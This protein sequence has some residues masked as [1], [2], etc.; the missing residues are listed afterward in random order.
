MV[1]C[2]ITIPIYKDPSKVEEASYRQ[3]LKILG[4]HDIC[5]LTFKEL[6]TSIYERIAD[7]YNVKVKFEFFDRMFFTSVSG[8]N[9]LCMSVDFYERFSIYEF[10]LIYQLDAWVF[11]DEL[12]Y[13]CEKNYDY[14]GA[15]IFYAY[16]GK[17]FTQKFCGI[18]NGGFTLR[19][20]SHCIKMLR[21]DQHKPFI[22]PL[23]LIELYYNYFLYADKFKPLKKK[24]RAI[25]TVLG[26]MFGFYN[27]LHYYISQHVNEDMLLGSWSDKSW[28]NHSYLPD[29]TE[30]SRFSFEL[31][32][33]YLYERNGN[34]LPFGCH[35]F[36]KWEY[37]SFWSKHINIR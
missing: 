14:I 34:K 28:G 16:N 5:L 37:D 18:G 4:S 26:K 23:P 10:L 29:F 11:R 19:K 15:P 30:A 32:P 35:A 21:S 6:D 25:P 3:C 20:I 7:E 9:D 12:D 36:M 17:K 33:A 24:L 13:W 8:Y 31:N 1:N 2:I 22:K 27:T